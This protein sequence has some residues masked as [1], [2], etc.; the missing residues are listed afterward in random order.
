MIKKILKIIKSIFIK[1]KTFPCIVW[2]GKKM[3]YP[4]LTNTQIKEIEKLPKYEGWRVM[5]NENVI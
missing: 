4:N 2:D 3:S 1:E 5:I